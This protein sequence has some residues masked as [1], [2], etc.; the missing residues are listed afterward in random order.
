MTETNTAISR[1]EIM[2]AANDIEPLPA[3]LSRLLSL[4]SEEDFDASE[5][6]EI[7][8]HD[9]ALAGDVLGLANS[10][11]YGA[12]R[13]IGD[14]REATARV[15]IREVVNIAMR[16]AMRARFATPLPAY[17]LQPDD[18]WRHCITAS[19]A[20]EIVRKAADV[21]VAPMISTA[22]LI[23]DVGKL[24]IARSIPENFVDLLLKAADAE[25]I[26]LDEAERRVLGLDHG[27]VGGV[28]ARTWGLPVSIQVALT[29]HHNPTGED[30]FTHALILSDLLAHA[31]V[32]LDEARADDGADEDLDESLAA[33]VPDVAQQLEVCGIDPAT[34]PALVTDVADGAADILS[35]Y[36]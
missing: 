8:S 10:S 29:Q 28:V 13:H 9:P 2:S 31:A 25:Q 22:A 19:V 1:G 18:L 27:E 30:V 4:L 14:L 17:G 16:R 7:L 15:G 33:M 34:V 20:A 23:H 35:D 12:Y 11:A 3:A 5:V 36:R 6:V 26:P 21:P 24:V 32:G